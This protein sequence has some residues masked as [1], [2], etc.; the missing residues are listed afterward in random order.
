MRPPTENKLGVALI[1]IARENYGLGAHMARYVMAH[2]HA[3]LLAIGS[4]SAERM[5]RFVGDAAQNGYGSIK[6]F[7]V[8]AME[9]LFALPEVD[10]VIIASPDATHLPYIRYGLKHR[11]NMWVEKPIV[12]LTQ[13][14]DG[15]EDLFAEADKHALTLGVNCQRAYIPR[16]LGCAKPQRNVEVK[17][18]MGTKHKHEDIKGL[19]NLLI[20]HP[21]SI[22]ATLGFDEPGAYTDLRYSV[23]AGGEL[24]FGFTYGQV[25]GNIILEQRHDAPFTTVDMRLD[26]EYIHVSPVEKNGAL[27]TEYRT[28]GRV[29]YSED[30]LK[31]S[32]CKLADYLLHGT[33]KP[34]VDNR[35][36]LRIARIEH[37]FYSLLTAR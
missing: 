18:A 15:L 5:E 25:E 9:S 12:P 8:D 1:G 36:G 23:M 32:F 11:K 22:L 2:P 10:L 21:V 19:V 4:R 30:L 33:G 3:R 16:F 35:A 13:N 6:T 14:P 7:G 17:V 31:L 28:N 37:T 27:L 34:V 29:A 24:C 20:S 26:D